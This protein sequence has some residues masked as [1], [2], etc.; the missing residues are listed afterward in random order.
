MTFSE[1]FAT[2]LPANSP[3]YPYQQRVADSLL[4][5]K[6]IVLQAPTGAGKTWA[7][8]APFLF[9]RHIET[10][11][12]D[13]LIY[14][15]PLRAL[16][17]NLHASVSQVANHATRTSLQIGGESNDPF[18]EADI[19]FTTIDQLLS[20]YLLHPV[21]LPPRLDNMNAGALPGAL[22][23]I[24]E[25]HLLDPQTALGTAVEML[26]TLQNFSQ[27]ILM[28][29]TLS[30]PA[31]DWLATS[32]RAERISLDPPEIANLPAQIG[33]TRS[34]LYR[35]ETLSVTRILD[36][37]NNQRT[38][39]LTNT[40][41]QAQRIYG[42]LKTQLAASGRKLFLL[43]SRFLPADRKAVESQL[44]IHFG[45]TAEPSNAI[46]VT[47]QVI[48]AGVDISAEKLHTE[49]APLNALIQRA[50]R[51]ARYKDRNQG[52]VFVYEASSKYPYE[53]SDLDR[54][55]IR[56]TIT[57][58]SPEDTWIDILHGQ[59]ERNHLQSRYG[60][61]KSRQN[62]VR[63][64]MEHKERACLTS[65]V[66]NIDSVNLLITATPDAQPFNSGHWPQS[67]SVPANSLGPLAALFQTPPPNTPWIAKRLVE[68]D[69]DSEFPRPRFRWDSVHTFP[70]AR[71]QW[72]LALHP[73]V[74]H[75]TAELGLILGSPGAE[76]P[77]T[78]VQRPPRTRYQYAVEEWIDHSR[79]VTAQAARQAPAYSVIAKRFASLS[80]HLED[81]VALACQCHDAGKLSTDWQQTAWNWQSRKCPHSPPSA[82]LAHTTSDPSDPPVKFPP[83]AVEGAFLVAQTV[84]EAMGL[85]AAKII[86]SAIA[87]HHGPRSYNITAITPIQNYQTALGNS[88]RI[89]L[90]PHLVLSPENKFEF[91]N[92]LINFTTTPEP[93]LWALY[94]TTV[95][96][97]RLA[98]QAATADPTG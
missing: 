4:A 83:H 46:L 75:Y 65:L 49:L 71:A 62:E 6:S 37:N 60:N 5:G 25:V 31:A 91:L 18:F 15:L 55:S 58:Q 69:Q 81:I 76:L 17:S 59:S 57:S 8:V 33:R 41:S 21:G 53:L 42:E 40:V 44:N 63:A 19:I 24:D 47:T 43:H 86:L 84:I 82:P 48:E 68:E 11:I 51:V 87:R 72:L 34:W 50:G 16:A 23:V 70:Q 12:A 90:R 77:Q 1:F 64:A 56:E 78:S 9:A 67:L 96:R 26:N 35:P 94:V 36:Q 97:L 28:T 52:Q 14:A 7:A 80:F 74:A 30:T 54:H 27:F 73:N 92:F 95:R 22:I 61:L 66:R 93:H 98:D 32:L 88:L 79:R 38:I 10:P 3:P 45:P 39:V 20:S 29:A 85:A 2:R 13:R 89:P